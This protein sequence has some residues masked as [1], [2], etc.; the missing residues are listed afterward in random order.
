MNIYSSVREDEQG[1]WV[2]KMWAIWTETSIEKGRI[3]LVAPCCCHFY[4]RD[5]TVKIDV[6]RA[7]PS[8]ANGAALVNCRARNRCL[9]SVI[10][11]LHHRGTLVLASRAPPISKLYEKECYRAPEKIGYEEREERHE[12]VRFWQDERK[13]VK[14]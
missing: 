14:A 2:Q 9:L 4:S 5:T 8:P 1:T 13:S 10:D 3:W 12:D 11:A 6:S 7:A